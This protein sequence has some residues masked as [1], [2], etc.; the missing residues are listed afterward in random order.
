MEDII[1]EI[2][3]EINDEF[4]VETADYKQLD[5]QNYLFEAKTSLNDFCRVFDLESVYFEKAKGESETLGGLMIELFG[6]IP[7]SG[8]ELT[9]ESFKFKIQSVD[10]RRIKKVKV[11]S[12]KKEEKVSENEV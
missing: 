8:E 9:Y 4:D 10:A 2:V 1:E 6:R 11:S 5:D 7:N 3:G 12:T